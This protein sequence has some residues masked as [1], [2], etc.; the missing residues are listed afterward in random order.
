MPSKCLK[1]ISAHRFLLNTVKRFQRISNNSPLHQLLFQELLWQSAEKERQALRSPLQQA[2]CSEYPQPTRTGATA[3]Q[4]SETADCISSTKPVTM[5]FL[6]SS[7]ARIESGG[8][9]PIT[10][11]TA[12]G[13]AFFMIGKISC[14]K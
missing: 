2:L 11:K 14:T 8:S 10:V 9:A 1:F 12:S 4:Q 7:S 6:P 5:I 3:R 13:T